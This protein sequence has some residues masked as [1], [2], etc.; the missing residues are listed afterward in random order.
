[1]SSLTC[2]ET[3]EL[4]RQ[5]GVPE[6]LHN[7]PVAHP[8]LGLLGNHVND[9]GLASYLMVL[10]DSYSSKQRSNTLLEVPPTVDFLNTRKE[11]LPLSLIQPANIQ[12]LI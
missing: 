7:S 6:Y 3:V 10:H 4:R 1:M 8:E 12:N 11:P 9:R 5:V 2:F